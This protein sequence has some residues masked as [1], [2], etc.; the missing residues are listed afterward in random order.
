MKLF[1]NLAEENILNY[2]SL[3]FFSLIQTFLIK[4]FEGLNNLNN[5][6]CVIKALKPSNNKI[7]FITELLILN[8]QIKEN[9]KRII[10]FIK[11]MWRAKHY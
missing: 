3:S 1:K 5:K 2:P 11:F 10:D 4:V 6:K 9:L 8:S 7:I